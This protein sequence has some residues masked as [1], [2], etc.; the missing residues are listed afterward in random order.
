ME[1]LHPP[2]GPA[3]AAVEGVLHEMIYLSFYL[4]W[5][6]AIPHNRLVTALTDRIQ[7][8]QAFK[9]ERQGRGSCSNACSA[10]HTRA[11]TDAHLECQPAL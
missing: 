7:L 8:L 2:F 10:R 4:I 9:K 3:A 11:C 6:F 1:S 5:T